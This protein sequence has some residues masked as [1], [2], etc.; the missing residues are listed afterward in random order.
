MH[1]VVLVALVVACNGSTPASPGECGDGTLD[2]TETC[3]EGALNGTAGVG[4]TSACTPACVDPAT[5]CGAAPAC[6]VAAC[7]T[8]DV[9]VFTAD[10][11]QDGTS[12]GTGEVCSNGAC[13]SMGMC[14]NGITEGS[15]DCDFGMDSG[16]TT[17]CNDN[18]TFS[19]TSST[20]CDDTNPC[21]GVET[22][23][24]VTVSGRQ[25]QNCLPGT[26]ENNGTSCGS[27]MICL[28]AACTASACG[29]SFA[30][31]PEECDDANVA[32]GDGC[33]N[34]CRFS[35]LSTDLARNCTPAD[36]CA[37]QGTCNDTT[38]TCTAGAPLA[39][40]TPCGTGGYC[41]SSTCTQPMC[42]NGDPEPGETCDDGNTVD[43]DGCDNDCTYSCVNAATDCGMPP[44][45]QTFTCSASHTCQAAA[46]TSQNSM[47]CGS[48]GET[49]NNGSCTGGVCGNGVVE[50][51]EQCD[52]VGGN[53]PGS[54]CEA[55]CQFSCTILPNS[56]DDLDPCNGTEMCAMI[57]VS[58]Q[59]GQ[60]CTSSAPLADNTVC[61]TGRICRSEQCVSS[62]CGDGFVDAAIGETC[63]PPNT[64]TCDPACHTV[65]VASC[66]D[67]VRAGAEQCDDG[68]STD[69]DGC[70]ASCKFEQ[71]HRMNR[72]DF[73][74][75][76]SAPYC[77]ANALGGA[78]GAQ[79]GKDLLTNAVEAGIADG[80]ITII[81]HALG[82]DD[83]SG[84]SDP[85]LSLG[86]LGGAPIAGPNFDGTNDP[87]WWYTVDATDIDATRT[88]TSTIL[89]SF[90]AK[91][92]NAGP[93]NMAFTV[94]F[95][96]TNVTMDMFN[97]RFR[98]T[99]GAATTPLVSTGT[100]PGHL[101]SENL[102]PAL[103][104]F[105]TMGTAAAP[106]EICGST[107][108]ASLDSTQIPAA[109]I[110]YCSNYTV[111]HTLL[112]LYIGGCNYLGFI[113][114][115]SVTQPD[116]A[117]TPGD[118]YRFQ[119]DAQRNVIGCTKNGAP[120]VLSDC[121]TNAGYSSYYRFT[122]ERVIAK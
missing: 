101:A 86:V 16:S 100:T 32:A 4:C 18:C 102:D 15:E 74:F 10:P 20:T 63:E 111:S 25:G 35:C 122:T 26:P 105:G 110:A 17:G 121:L 29:D 1:R 55:D 77:A 21:N 62:T 117:R 82:L 95:V 115:L 59:A 76:T 13:V 46:D 58:G 64:A 90:A 113:T 94:S 108:A 5:D 33:E 98:A 93:G 49:C 78:F 118:V 80:S 11:I 47:A 34:N 23:G 30:T 92:L 40:N 109:L 39:D 104:S 97:T 81:L 37:G 83:L 116:T 22:C 106:G 42:G 68:N 19:C 45:C 61:S 53:G 36:A 50:A 27:G 89:A 43:G 41:L 87:D 67:G 99:T 52:F 85:A 91:V 75:G 2:A 79:A 73:Q 65:T 72:L 51:G 8:D 7:T 24:P 103:T 66:G 38:H 70:N 107:A 88:P 48:N 54:G 96:G 12:C 69:L 56:C 6:Q 120:G 3:D 9:C 57:S 28:N 84:T 71:S 60:Q 14:G 119:A 44:A 31:A 114:V 112:D